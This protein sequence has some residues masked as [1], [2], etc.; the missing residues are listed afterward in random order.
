MRVLGLVEDAHDGNKVV[1]LVKCLKLETFERVLCGFSEGNAIDDNED[2]D[3]ES[4]TGLS[5]VGL[6]N[7]DDADAQV[8]EDQLNGIEKLEV[9][10]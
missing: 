7:C 4:I 2:D 8:F 5:Y 3:G 6:L 10:I 9:G 1:G